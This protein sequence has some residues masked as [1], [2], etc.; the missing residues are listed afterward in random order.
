MYKIKENNF[1]DTGKCSYEDEYGN[2]A[3]FTRTEN[4]FNA[5]LSLYDKKIR[6]ETVH[7]RY[8]LSGE[9]FHLVLNKS[10]NTKDVTDGIDGFI[11][12]L[13]HWMKMMMDIDF[14]LTKN[15]QIHSVRPC[16]DKEIWEEK[17]YRIEQY[18][19]LAQVKA[20]MRSGIA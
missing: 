2:H 13:H 18:P 12:L 14:Y 4:G 9:G 5:K 16:T 19:E 17:V 20:F 8:P 11:T 15:D 1:I 6:A 3:Y 10:C 7:I